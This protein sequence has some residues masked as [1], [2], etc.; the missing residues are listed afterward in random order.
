MLINQMSGSALR[1]CI[2]CV[3]TVCLVCSGARAN[4]DC[5]EDCLLTAAPVEG[6][7]RLD[8]VLDEAAWQGAAV[9][10]GFTQYSPD[11]GSPA[12]QS[13]EVRV[14]YGSSALYIS[15]LMQD[16]DPS[17]IRRLLGRRDEF[18]QADWFIASI[19]S[20]YDRKTA[21]N[22]AVSAAGVQ[23]DGIYTGQRFGGGGGGFGF[24]TSWDAV[25]RSAVRHGPEGWTVEM[26]IPYTMLRFSDASVQRWGI[27]FR[28][29]IPRLGE[30]DDWV[31]IPRADRSSGTVAQYGILEGM[32]DIHNH[33]N[34]QVTPYS[35]ASMHSEEGDVAGQAVRSR[36]GDIGGDIK[37]GIST[38]ITLDATINPDFGQVEAD[39]AELNLSAFETF[40]RERRPFFTE[41]VQIFQFDLDRGGTLLYTRRIGARAPVLGAAKLSGRTGEG[42]SFGFFGASTGDHFSPDQHYGVGRMRQQLG[43]L[44][45]VGG[46]ATFYTGI[47]G[48]RS[49]AGG[50]DWDMRFRENR[51]R[52]N[53]QLS[54]ARRDTENAL[55][56]GYALTASF[57]RQRSDWNWG[58]DLTVVSDDFNPNDVG[59]MRRNNFMSFSGGTFHQVNGG[60]PFGPF[61]RASAFMYFGTGYSYDEFLHDGAGFFFRSDWTLLGYQEL[62]LGMRSDFM[63]GGYDIF[64]T[65]GLDP[66]A[67]PREL[68][69]EMEYATDSRKKWRL[70]PAAELELYGDGGNALATGL[71][72]AW[73]A[74]SRLDLSLE[75]AIER[76]FGLTEWASNE[77]FAR[78]DGIWAIAETSG[79][80]PDEVADWR[81]LGLDPLGIGALDSRAPWDEQGRLYVPVFGERDTRA[82]D[83]TLRSSVT[84]TPKLSIQVYGQLFAARGSYDHF[85]LLQ[86]RDSLIPVSGFPKL[87]DFAFSR[88]QTNTVLRWEYRPGSTLYLVWTQSRSGSQDLDPFDRLSRS[89]YDQRTGTQLTDTFD[90]FPTNVLLVK[91]S[92]KFLR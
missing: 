27:N 26:R 9:A 40:F 35:V 2:A 33:R 13:T 34:F 20:Y 76:E 25:W 68:N 32:T 45:N 72:V 36:V 85:S 15:A 58:M 60:Q 24:E 52:W 47:G 73:A 21:Y 28:R 39:P 79:D 54:G 10:G 80:S 90:Y 71:E 91:F 46:M 87:Y 70:E 6:D 48:H 66:R 49:L 17:G 12:T 89:P 69:L 75:L 55:E 43:E 41:G 84:L 50:V 77:A 8:G 37:L 5:P 86:D 11:E 61:R 81:E 22:F 63:F 59:R 14:L 16:D 23:A 4:P 3:A 38:N 31:L 82:T 88:F 83:F 62:E 51:Y 42:L 29:I 53:G 30:I 7:I 78:V 56:Q 57:D 92:Y 74:T 1:M 18:N 65:R 64:E 19:D 44:S 67:R